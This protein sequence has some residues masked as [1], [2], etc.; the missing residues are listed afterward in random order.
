MAPKKIIFMFQMRLKS[1][2]IHLGAA[3]STVMGKYLRILLFELSMSR[4]THIGLSQTSPVPNANRMIKLMM[5]RKMMMGMGMVRLLMK[6]K[7][8]MMMPMGRL[9]WLP[10]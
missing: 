10:I 5:L 1:R 9:V 8:V 3:L 2:F 7:S 6:V 4:F